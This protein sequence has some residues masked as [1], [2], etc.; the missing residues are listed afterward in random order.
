ME[1]NSLKSQTASKSSAKNTTPQLVT[2]T[3]LLAQGDDVIPIPGTKKIKVCVNNFIHYHTHVLTENHVV[4][5]GKY[6]GY[7]GA[8][9]CG[10]GGRF[11]V[12]RH[13]GAEV[14]LMDGG[15]ASIMDWLE[16]TAQHV[17]RY[18]L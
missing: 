8:R 3:W 2:F 11:V 4:R 9:D 1:E 10:K 12:R 17:E 6:W 15:H 16:H 5:R 18:T 7:E 13:H 14:R